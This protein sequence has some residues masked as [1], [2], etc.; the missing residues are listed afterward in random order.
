M[1]PRP[2]DLTEGELFD[3]LREAMKHEVFTER[4]LRRLKELL[5]SVP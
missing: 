5:S 2:L 1:M 4:F 3:L